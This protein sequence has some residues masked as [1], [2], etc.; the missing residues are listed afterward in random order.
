M[1]W[2]EVIPKLIPNK[3]DWILDAVLATW[4]STQL[5]S[6]FGKLCVFICM[7]QPANVAI[8]NCFWYV[9]QSHSELPQ[10]L[11]YGTVFYYSVDM[12]LGRVVLLQDTF[13]GFGLELGVPEFLFCLWNWYLCSDKYQRESFVL[14]STLVVWCFASL[15]CLKAVAVFLSTWLLINTEFSVLFSQSCLVI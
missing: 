9:K 7:K 2:H 1:Q 11:P 8:S 15:P 14:C 10:P 13:E 12:S 4:H 5:I 3:L 6:S